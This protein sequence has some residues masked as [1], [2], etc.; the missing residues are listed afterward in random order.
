MPPTLQDIQHYLHT[1]LTPFVTTGADLDQWLADLFEAPN[2]FGQLLGMNLYI[3]LKTE[4]IEERDVAK[5]LNKM[6]RDRDP[7]SSFYRCIEDVNNQSSCLCQHRSGQQNMDADQY[8]RVMPF[9]SMARYC[10]ESLTKTNTPEAQAEIEE[11][12]YADDPDERAPLGLLRALWRGRMD[13]VWVTSK[14]ELDQVLS[15]SIGSEKKA[16]QLRTRLGFYEYDT[17]RLVFVAYPP[18]SNYAAFQPTSLDAN[19]TCF[20]FVSKQRQ[21][22]DTWGETCSLNPTLPGMKERVHRGFQGLTD[23]FESEIIGTVEPSEADLNHLLSVAWSRV[24]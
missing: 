12:F 7:R 13:N 22:N 19:S 14:V 4:A 17:G 8:V 23:D 18:S 1:K 6:I 11:M 24:P 5:I 3:D 21:P 15:L 2:T 10:C 9:T 20:F 16:S